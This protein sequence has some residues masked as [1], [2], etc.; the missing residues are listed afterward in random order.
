M[1]EHVRREAAEIITSAVINS[2]I[3]GKSKPIQLEVMDVETCFDKLW[4]EACINSLYEAGLQDDRLNILYIENKTANIAVKIYNKVSRRTPVNKVVMQGS[5]WGGLKCTSQ[6]DT[7]NKIM[8]NK[9]SLEYK[10]RNDPNITIG[11]IG[12]IDDTLAVAECGASSVEKNSVVNSF[13]ETHRLSM[14]KEKSVVVHVGNV[15]NCSQ[16]CPTLK[17][18]KDEMQKVENVKYLGNIISSHGGIGDTVEDRRKRGWGKVSQILGILGEVDTG[19]HRI[20]AGLILREAILTSSLLFTAEAWHNVT[21]TDVRRLEQVDTALLRSLVKGHSKT[22]IIFHH[23]EFGTLMLRHMIRM[24]RI[25]YHHHIIGRNESETIKKI[26]KKQKEEPLKGDWYSLLIEDFKFIGIDINEEVIRNTPK[27]EYKKKIKKLIKIAAYEE[28][29]NLKKGKK[30]VM[31]VKYQ[32]LEVQKYLI[33]PD[34]ST[35]KR[36]LLYALRSRMHASKSNFRKM[37]SGNLLCS[38]G[39]QYEEDQTHIFQ[40][41]QI[42]NINKEQVNLGF[43]FQDINKQK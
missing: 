25:M 22:P 42:L 2:V 34:F 11:V 16:P 18:H 43:I 1:L 13:M 24:K 8:K 5:V 27:I 35:E 7:L 40:N 9:E 19:T 14:H 37:N 32:G 26:C 39:C 29:N 33:D 4:L 10:Y 31:D 41:C 20:E 36:N 3:R 30:K 12:M 38:Q 17:V 23:L 15:R 28:M 21:D 6:M